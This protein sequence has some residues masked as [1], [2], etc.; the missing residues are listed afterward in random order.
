M[1]FAEWAGTTHCKYCFSLSHSEQ[2][3]ELSPAP[4]Q[5]SDTQTKSSSTAPATQSF[6]IRQ[7]PIC[8]EC[9]YNPAPCCPIPRC[10][11]RHIYLPCSRNPRIIDRS[12]KAMFC[13]NFPGQTPTHITIPSLTTIIPAIPG[14]AG[15]G[16]L[17]GLQQ[18]TQWVSAF[19]TLL[20]MHVITRVIA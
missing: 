4:S 1:A 15:F 14:S 10:R 11:Y 2:H 17:A 7:C 6:Q 9:N 3:C 13:P 8:N 5:T 19:S 20:N 16:I 12:H 18:S